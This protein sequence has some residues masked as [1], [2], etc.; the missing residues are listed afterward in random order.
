M[1]AMLRRKEMIGKP[2]AKMVTQLA[3]N[4]FPGLESMI[5]TRR[6]AIS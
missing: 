5:I 4:Y 3:M 6:I 2:N 1:A